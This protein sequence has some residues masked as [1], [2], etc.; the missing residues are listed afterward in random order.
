MNESDL[1]QKYSHEDEYEKKYSSEDRDQDLNVS[2][3]F[4]ED[5]EQGNELYYEEAAIDSEKKYETFAEF[6]RI[7]VSCIKCKKVFSFRNKLHKHL[8][9]DCKTIE[10]KKATRD[11]FVKLI[12]TS[13]SRTSD[14]KTSTIMK[15]TMFTANKN[16]EL[17]FR[18]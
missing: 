10:S 5:D 17:V 15:F 7:E 9:E 13:N 11:K 6:V 4:A 2:V 16:Y 12:D 18:K 1:K 14:S 3:N 8:K